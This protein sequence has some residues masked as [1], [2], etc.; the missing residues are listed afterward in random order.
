MAMSVRIIAAASV[1]AL[2]VTVGACGSADES[3]SSSDGGQPPS[4]SDIPADL[5]LPG[6]DYSYTVNAGCGERAGLVGLYRIRVAGGEV[7]HVWP[8]SG[9]GG[10]EA[11]LTDVPTID[12]LVEEA[13]TAEQEGADE[14]TVTT[15]PQ[16]YPHRIKI[17]QIADAID[18]EVCYTISDVVREGGKVQVWTKPRPT[19][20]WTKQR[21]LRLTTYGSSSCPWVPAAVD[22]RGSQ[23]VTIRLKGPDRDEICTMDLAPHHSIVKLPSRIDR[24]AD[25]LTFVLLAPAH[26]PLVLTVEQNPMLRGAPR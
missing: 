18:D 24:R 16:D 2:G 4:G 17:D 10:G 20:G 22:A 13:E 14:V 8:L 5:T 25:Q 15:S 7:A 21:E 9:G 3:D 12:Q 1:V 11:A 23:S 6:S 19:I 26:Q